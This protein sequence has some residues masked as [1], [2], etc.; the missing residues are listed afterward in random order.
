MPNTMKELSILS[1]PKSDGTLQEYEIV[2]SALRQSVENNKPNW[3]AAEI[4]DSESGEVTGYEDG[5]ISNKPSIKAGEGENSIIEGKIEDDDNSKVYTIYLTGEAGATTFTYTTEDEITRNEITEKTNLL[6]Q[7]G[8][9]YS[10]T[11]SNTLYRTSRISKIDSENSTITLKNIIQP[12]TK[13][14][15]NQQA[16]IY[17]QNKNIAIS[18]YCHAEGKST[19]AYMTGAHAEGVYT[20]AVGSYAHAEGYATT[21]MLQYSHA[22]GNKTRASGLGAHAEGS[23]TTAN[24]GYTHA[25]GYYTKALDQ[26]CHSE[27]HNTNASKGASHA[28]GRNTIASGSCSHAEG[29]FALA[30][31]IGSHAEG[32]V[33]CVYINLTGEPNATTYN[34]TQNY[35][36]NTILL[37]KMAHTKIISNTDNTKFQLNASSYSTITNIDFDNSTITVD[38]TLSDTAISD[39]Q[40]YIY[41]RTEANG[42]AS[43]A[44]GLSS[45][46]SGEGSHAE[47][48]QTL[49]SGTYSHAE[50]SLTTASGNNSHASGELT[51]AA[52]KAQT[53]IGT[54]NIPDDN[55]TNLHPSQY[56][57]F[58]KYA[59][60]VGNGY[61]TG[62]ASNAHTLDWQGNGWYAGKLTVGSAPTDNM[63]VATKQY[64]DTSISGITDNN[65]TYDLSITDNV[66]ALT[67]SD[68][69][70]SNITLP[71]YDGSSDSS[72]D[73]G[74]SG[75]VSTLSDLSDVSISNLTSGQI[76]R[77]NGTEWGNST[78]TWAE[79]TEVASGNLFNPDEII[80]TTMFMPDGTT[81]GWDGFCEYISIEVGLYTFLA[82]H[83]VYSGNTGA[84]PLFDANKTFV[85]TIRGTTAEYDASHTAVTITIASSD[86]SDGCAYFGFSDVTSYLAT[87]MVV[88]GTTYPD[89]YI[90]PGTIRTIEGLQI[91]QS[92]I[93]DLD[94]S[95]NPLSGKK[96]SFNG[97]SICYGVG[98]AGGYASIIGQENDMT[99][100][101]V[102]VSGATIAPVEGVSHCI[103]TSIDTMSLDADYVILEGGVN[104]ADRN[105]SVGTLTTGYEDTLDTTTFAG[106]F[107]NMLKSA[108]TRF[109]DKKLGY[110]FIHKCGNFNQDYYNIA[111]TACEKWGVPYCDLNTKV[112]P[113]GRITALASAYTSD[114]DGYHPNADGYTKFYVPKIT[115]WMKTL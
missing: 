1:V 33:Y 94:I 102:A 11:G 105:V 44:E 5:Y 29:N 84:V 68:N 89:S 103:S 31:G 92:Q 83:D 75:N 19:F 10:P 13:A 4:L 8:I 28:E 62:G 12:K 81:F 112:P 24:S 7:I 111:K 78:P 51:T 61:D 47:G 46:A 107:E 93:T 64:V 100:E 21:A 14:V 76:L 3:N 74:Q 43:H 38:T 97:D 79:V 9:V 110:I 16:F 41:I 56:S 71:V 37:L 90:A 85:K 101:N 50:G 65:T 59:F 17:Y 58:G 45:L 49:A 99:I 104:D 113:I 26:S 27:G 86:I 73:G 60:I 32:N 80:T 18:N 40:Y 22:E 23:L 69:S 48:R 25:E 115:A 57:G 95:S 108:I 63:D 39:A 53:V 35:T 109:P 87:A 55:T 52:T 114:G 6:E 77:Y 67:G 82:P 54:Y 66:I 98:S 2:D 88:K 34:F 15:E 70:T 96:A 30:S 20:A 72:G 91:S 42:T 106:A 36:S